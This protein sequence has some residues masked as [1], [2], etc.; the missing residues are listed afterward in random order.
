[1]GFGVPWKKPKL[2][3][4][5]VI[6][7]KSVALAANDTV[8]GDTVVLFADISGPLREVVQ[9]MPDLVGNQYSIMPMKVVD[10]IAFD[11][12][13]FDVVD[14]IVMDFHSMLDVV[15][16]GLSPSVSE[17][18]RKEVARKNPKW[19]ATS[20]H[21]N[22]NPRARTNAYKSSDY[23][24]VRYHV[25][26]WASTIIG[27]LGFNQLTVD[28]PIIRFLSSVKFFS[29]FVGL[30]ASL[31]LLALAFL[32]LVLI[33]SLLNVGVETRVYEL[34]IHRMLGFT[35]ES[36]VL[37][38]LTNAYFFTI[39]AWIAGLAI[40]Q[41]IYLGL[42]SIV[43]A[44]ISVQLPLLVP[45]EAIGWATFAG[46]M[47]P[48]IGSILP[49]ISL[50]SQNLPDA[51]NS[52]RGKN[53][54]V[55]YKIVRERDA[56]G[57]DITM[58]ALGIAFAVFGFLLYYLFPIG[59]VQSQLALLFGI[60]LGVLIGM[61]TGL[62]ILSLNLERLLQSMVSYLFLF[63]EGS[64][65]F[66]AVHV[67]LKA[68]RRRNRTTTLMYA[69]SLGFVMFITIAVQL[70]LRSFQYDMRRATGAEVVVS[71]D[72][73]A[74]R[75]LGP[76]AMFV[77]T[78]L[79]AV[80]ALTYLSR[81]I[82]YGKPLQNVTLSSP[83]RFR[84][85][86]ARGVRG[87]PPNFFEVLDKKFLLVDRYN[88]RSRQYSLAGALYT[89]GR[90]QLIMSASAYSTINSNSLEDPMM[91][92]TALTT[93]TVKKTAKSVRYAV[94]PSA[95]L[96]AAPHVT[97]SK[98]RSVDCDVLVSYPTALR[99]SS[100]D[101]L[102][103]RS[104]ALESV[105]LRVPDPRR[106]SS[107]SRAVSKYLTN[108]RFEYYSVRDDASTTEYLS[109]AENIMGFFFTF[110]QVMTLAICF[111]SLLSSMTANVMQSSKE[112]GIYRC[113]GMTKF[114]IYRIFVWEA[115][116]VVVAAGIMGVVVGVV[117]GYTMQ[118]Q[119]YLFTQL[120]VPLSFPYFQV[121]TIVIMAVAAALLASYG[122]VALLMRL[123]SITHILRRTV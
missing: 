62:V 24:T 82:T 42:R 102:S 75:H 94:Q 43:S 16:E 50:V 116:T 36:L 76:F 68:H 3:R 93:N 27:P 74:L 97:M 25:T 58:F 80:T 7:S 54:G 38:V 23:A 95:V 112:I 30:I 67:C 33:Y 119:N 91:L 49:I 41:L 114:Q 29:L 2:Q 28:T 123:P 98:F 32:S 15:A 19:C 59:M 120:P 115:F 71:S 106:L 12:A 84:T 20:I 21:F 85:V 53:S 51:L 64:A 118:L 111:F 79:S 57:F 83:G 61:L 88:R 11:T 87:V 45:G 105:T 17:A 78:Q 39:P 35:R 73:L 46:L 72:S 90:N 37:M 48:L 1:M 4:G 107:V 101:Y 65:V 110:T 55:L 8:V 34:G 92:V 89:E 60:F 104:I 122:P 96:S 26:S 69:L 44:I 22:L 14:F 121:V 81:S 5:E 66:Q 103:V 117:V 31:M 109:I 63:W 108:S 113:I 9:G 10:I 100:I 56:S 86:L 47:L 6:L 99:V 52:S 13:K 70:Q 77:K 40:G 18:T